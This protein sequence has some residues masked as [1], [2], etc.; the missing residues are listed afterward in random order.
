[1]KTRPPICLACPAYPHGQGFVPAEG[2]QDAT[3]AILGQGP[4]ES[5]MDQGRPF[6]GP[7]GWTLDRW[8]VRAKLERHR[9][10]VTNIV[11]C[12]L[13]GNRA[14]TR[15]EVDY[16]RAAH[17]GPALAALPDLNV[18]VPVGVPAGKAI[19]G[20]KFSAAAAGVVRKVELPTT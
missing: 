19:L 13:R 17:W 15:A 11:W 6:V 14:P 3:I 12:R 9:L 5:E 8:L 20:A 10:H 2:P 7:S 16:C 18:L 4:G 1:M